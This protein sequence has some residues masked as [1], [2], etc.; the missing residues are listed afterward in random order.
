MKGDFYMKLKNSR[1]EVALMEKG[2]EIIS[3]TDIQT[4]I[5]YMWQGDKENWSGKN[6][7]LFPIIGNTFS[8]T[9]E[10][11]GKTYQMNN[12]GLIRS[13]EL[14]CIRDDGGE[15]V[16]ELN[17]DET[18]LA[19]YP[20]PFHYEISYK[21]RDNKLTITYHITNTGR[22][23]MPF[24]FG[25][26]P[27]FNC[28]LCEGEKFEDYSMTFSNP[29]D[30]EQLIFD[31]KKKKP[32]TLKPVQLQ[33]IPCDYAEIEKYATLIYKNPK[34]AYLTLKGKKDHGVRIS[35]NGYPYL[36]IWTAKKGAPFICLEPWYGHADF[37]EVEE[38]FYHR[39]G[40]MSLSPKKTFTTSY[41]IEVF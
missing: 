20:F 30:F 11:D 36:A 1:Y 13:A 32:Y 5:Q 18:T 25:L 12:H 7:S 9:Y 41:T 38:D 6:P 8:K 16:M 27:G 19:Q 14:T 37:S 4:G 31:A 24:T 21:L 39:E 29:E 34:S 35:L 33:T 23:I 2:G 28:P 22:K 26:H 40:T 3:F 15:V 17:S 10:I